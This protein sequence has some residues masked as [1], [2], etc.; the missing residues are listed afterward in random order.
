MTSKLDKKTNLL[1][2]SGNSEFLERTLLV[3][4]ESASKN[5]RCEFRW[6]AI[7]SAV[8]LI[9]GAFLIKHGGLFDYAESPAFSWFWILCLSIWLIPTWRQHGRWHACAQGDSMEESGPKYE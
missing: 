6:A 2:L 5:Y 1:Y 7:A 9:V 8:L 4:N 3:M